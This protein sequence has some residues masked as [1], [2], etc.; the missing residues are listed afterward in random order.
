[1][2]H[3]YLIPVRR[4]HSEEFLKCQQKSWQLFFSYFEL[5][6]VAFQQ[7]LET[8]IASSG[9]V[10][11]LWYVDRRCNTDHVTFLCKRKFYM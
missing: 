7:L 9:P 2:N 10:L 3:F 8:V 4:S 5:F 11:Y 6:S 1:M